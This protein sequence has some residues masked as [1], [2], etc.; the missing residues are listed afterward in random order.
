MPYGVLGEDLQIKVL[1]NNPS[2]LNVIL[3]QIKYEDKQHDLNQPL[4]ANLLFSKNFKTK[5][6]GPSAVPTGLFK[7]AVKECIRLKR[8]N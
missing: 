8:Q 2:P 7:K 4:Q 6:S 3:K 1:I 5:V